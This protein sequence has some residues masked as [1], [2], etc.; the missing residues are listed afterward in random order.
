MA[1]MAPEY[2]KTKTEVQGMIDSIGDDEITPELLLMIDYA[3]HNTD[4]NYDDGLSF[5]DR[6]YSKL[7]IYFPIQWNVNNLKVSIRN[8]KTPS[9]TFVAILNE[10]LTTDMIEW[11][12]L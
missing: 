4:K 9:V 1:T 7:A 8:S 3:Y 6:L 5:L 11:Y 12:G 2:R 10:I